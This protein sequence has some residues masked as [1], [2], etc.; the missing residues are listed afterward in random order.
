MSTKTFILD[1]SVLMYD[2]ERAFTSF[3]DNDVIIPL[4]VFAELDG[5]SKDPVKG[6]KAKAVIHRFHE[7]FDG[8]N[9]TAGI[10]TPGGGTLRI[11]ADGN[12][13]SSII[14]KGFD[15]NKADN[16]MIAT[17][18]IHTKNSKPGTQV[19]LV[20]KDPCMKI[21]AQSQGVM[22]QD[23]LAGKVPEKTLTGK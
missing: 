1:T 7:L 8:R 19:I 12:F 13:S 3:E 23:Y 16:L 21:L 2:P 22:A 20:S 9:T 18:V 6:E 11:D 17:A 10:S 15:P 5:L 14:P 4:I